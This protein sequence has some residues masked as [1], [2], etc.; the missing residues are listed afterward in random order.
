VALEG[1]MHPLLRETKSRFQPAVRAVLQTQHAD[2][3]DEAALPAY[4]HTN[5][6]IDMIFWRRLSVAFAEACRQGG[7]RALD[8]GCGTGL[9]SE[10]LAKAGFTVTAIDLDLAPKRLLDNQIGF[11]PSIVFVEGDALGLRLPAGSFDVILALDVLEHIAPL[12]P[13][14]REFERLLGPGGVLIVSGPTENWL[15]RLGRKLAGERFTGHYHVCD[16]YDVAESARESFEVRRLERIIWPATLFEVLAC[17][18]RA[19]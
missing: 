7:R 6:L 15:Y 18:K 5:P 10:T 13:Y 9:M 4:A 16:I 1:M 17:R 3:L 8:F 14:L 12:G 2:R 11:A 19:R